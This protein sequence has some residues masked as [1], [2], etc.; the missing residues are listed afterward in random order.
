MGLDPVHGVAVVTQT[1]DIVNSGPGKDHVMICPL[2]RVKLGAVLENIQK[3]RTLAAAALE[4]PPEPDIVV[5]IGRM[6]PLHKDALAKLER[7]DGLTT[8]AGRMQFA[9]TLER[10]FGRFAFPDEFN[11][12]IL[13]KLR[14]RVIS[15]HGKAA[16][17]HGKAYRSIKTVRVTASPGWNASEDKKVV[18]HFILEPEAAREANRVQIA[19]TL[20]EHFSKLAWPT[21]FA[22]ASPPYYLALPEEMTVDEWLRSQ[23]IDWEFISFAGRAIG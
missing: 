22:A 9:E 8:D 1:C 14:E 6:A 16:S 21:G 5:D 2:I 18:F 13:T 17:D 10:K 3:G 11:D 15:A 23:P 4:N 12:R 7:H 19:K 20:D